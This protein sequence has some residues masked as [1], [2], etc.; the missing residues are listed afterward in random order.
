ME[1]F[2]WAEF[3]YKDWEA[4]EKWF[5][6]VCGMEWG[7][8]HEVFRDDLMQHVRERYVVLLACQSCSWGKWNKSGIPCEHVLDIISFNGTDPEDFVAEWFKRG[9]YLKAY[10]YIVNL[11]KGREFLPISDEGP[12]QP[13]V[14]KK[15]ALKTYQEEEEK[16]TRGK[17]MA[18]KKRCLGMVECSSVQFA[19]KKGIKS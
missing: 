8:K 13:V 11:V 5:K 9:T 12:L 17:K 1:N 18:I 10:T 4:K 14:V 3:C 19:M 6:V 7:C 15:S 2:L 16:A